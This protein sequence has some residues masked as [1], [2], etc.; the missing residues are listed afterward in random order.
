MRARRRTDSLSNQEFFITMIEAELSKATAR[1]ARL[2]QQQQQQYANQHTHLG[3]PQHHDD[4]HADATHEY[5]TNSTTV[6]LFKRAQAAQDE[7]NYIGLN[8][9]VVKL[10]TEIT[11]DADA[12][13]APSNN[14]SSLGKAT[15]TC[16]KLGLLLLLQHTNIDNPSKNVVVDNSSTLH[17]GEQTKSGQFYN[18]LQQWY[19][20]LYTS[21]QSMATHAFRMGLRK[22]APEYP[23]NEHSSTLILEN[24]QN[25]SANGGGVYGDN[26]REWGLAARCLVELQ[27]IHDALKQVQTIRSGDETET[28]DSNQWRLTIVDELCKPLADR[29]RFHFLEEQTAIMTGGDPSTP[30]GNQQQ[31]QQ[32][33]KASKLDRLPEWLF[34]YLRETIENHG[35]YSLVMME[36]V[37]PMID[38]VL[39]SLSVRA[40]IMMS[41]VDD[42]GE[43]TGDVLMSGL[44]NNDTATIAEAQTTPSTQDVLEGLRDKY[45]NHASIY[46]LREVARMARH[47]LRAKSFFHHPDVVGSECRD[48]TIALRGIEQLLMFD[49]FLQ[50]RMNE[51]GDG[52]GVYGSPTMSSVVVPPKM[53]DTFLSS[54]EM[55]LKWWLEEERDGIISSLHQ[56]A[57]R[58]LPS[59]QNDDEEDLAGEV[60]PSSK[61][62]T[63]IQD[64]QQLY[65]PISEHFVA[66]LHSA[67]CKSNIFNKIRSRQLYVSNVIAPLCSEYLDMIA[68]AASLLRKKLLARPPTLSATTSVSILRSANLP[69]VELIASNTMEWASLVTGAHISAQAVLHPP[70]N[71]YHQNNEEHDSNLLDRVGESME[72]LC[73][74]MVEDFT[75]AYIETIIME[76]AKFASYMMR[77][78]FLL[79]EPPAQDSPGRRGQRDKDQT[80]RSLSLSPD[81]NDSIHIMSVGVKVCN[82]V[83]SKLSTMFDKDG[84][85]S[86]S[87]MLHFGCRS[88]QESL[89]FAISQKLLD[90]ALDPQGMS[91]EIYVAGAKQFQHDVSAFDRLFRSAGGG[92]EIKLAANNVTNH[93]PMERV[94]TASRLMSLEP[95]SIQAI[96]EA[97]NSLAVP[98]SSIGSL[99]GR[100]GDTGEVDIHYEESAQRLNVDDFYRDERLMEEATNMLEAKGFGALAL[101]ESLSIINRRC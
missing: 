19:N 98:T 17:L 84:K 36:G 13:N 101:D 27:V 43:G 41:M 49:S 95:G 100:M 16:T 67:R 39:D 47:T 28:D 12:D 1:L 66:L 26:N 31:Q 83:L 18:S 37:Q 51:C 7:I 82:S 35:V 44:T 57:M 30:L 88:I 24:L 99:F 54:N 21:T 6:E 97:L 53:V 10:V 90:I 46:F 89:K 87:I 75:S 92:A 81:L 58:S 94:V 20:S 9:T 63:P 56:C 59:Y 64:V 61:R 62:T 65:P 73:D 14:K 8:R 76:R 4:E 55:L 91:P 80:P 11:K 60:V 42:E 93:G 23:S 68:E 72:R 70:H 85:S 32:Q 77:A 15:E 45:Y 96:R 86:T 3:A 48:R 38:S 2:Q 29:L 33:Q 25:I 5:H 50:E 34:R 52:E 22:V 71:T 74:A 79:S 78:P 40:S 69:S